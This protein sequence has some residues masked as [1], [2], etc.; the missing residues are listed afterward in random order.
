MTTTKS[1]RTICLHGPESVG[2]S[3]LAGKL[4]AHLGG[5]LVEEYGRAYCQMHGV[6]CD[7]NDLLTIAQTQQS[8]I[9]AAMPRKHGW[10]VTDTDALM[11]AVW[12]DMMLG[13]RDPWFADFT[14]YADLYLLLDIDLPFHHDGLRLYGRATKRQRFFT[15]CEAE[16][17]A[18]GVPWALVRGSGA[19]RLENAL[20]A[21]AA[22]FGAADMSERA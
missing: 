21:I 11:T 15:L 14:D 6:D 2:K 16:L 7:M 17:A 10:V 12:A 8:M 3:V 22:H 19:A 5:V 9:A 13:A 18:R 20:A 4:A 1:A